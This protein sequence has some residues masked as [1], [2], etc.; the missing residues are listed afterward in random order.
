MVAVVASMK[1]GQNGKLRVPVVHLA[2]P[3]Y[4][5]VYL[6]DDRPGHKVLFVMLFYL[7]LS[8]F[9]TQYLVEDT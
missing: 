2:P 3:A 8:A 7:N 5:W 1:S 4:R 6:P 9:L